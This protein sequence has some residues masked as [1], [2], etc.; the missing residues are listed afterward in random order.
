MVLAVFYLVGDLVPTNLLLDTIDASSIMQRQRAH[1]HRI[2][3]FARSL[4]E[5]AKA[6]F[7]EK[8]LQTV[9]K[10]VARRTRDFRARPDKLTL[11]RR[12]SPYNAILRWICLHAALSV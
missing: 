4:A 5:A 11:D 8:R 1:Q 2:M 12:L 3:R 6:S 10:H 7:G 9:V